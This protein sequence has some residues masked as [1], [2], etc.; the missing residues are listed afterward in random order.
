MHVIGTAGHVDHGKSSL[1][2]R[3]TGINPDRL[4]VEQDREM[5]IELG[6]AWLQLPNGEDIGIVDVPGHRDFIENML[7]GVGGIDAAL[8]VVAADEGV[9]PQ[10]REHL[11]IL[12]L[13]Q[14]PAGLIALN[15]VDL[16]DD[17]EWL[18]LVETDLKDILAGTV[19][20]N[21][22]I[23]RVSARTGAGLENLLQH[24]QDILS[25]HPH[26]PDLGRPRLPVDRVFTL[27]GFGTIVTG[28][29]LDGH[30]S[31]GDTVEIL[32]AGITGRIRSLQTHKQSEEKAVPGSR[33]AVN[34]SG[35]HVDQIKRGDVITYP[36][37][38]E[39]TKMMDVWCTLLDDIDSPLKHN[40]EVKLFLG[41]AEVMAR[42]R[43]LGVQELEPGKDTFL[44][45]MLQ[46]P[47]VAQRQDR[48]IIRRP[49]PSA[50]IGGGQ[51]VDPHPLR[52]HKRF[53]PD[54]LAELEQL[55]VGTPEEILMQSAHSLVA[56]Q[57][58]EIIAVSGLEPDIAN[59][60]LKVLLENG[61]LLAL[62]GSRIIIP[63]DM[64]QQMKNTMEEILSAYHDQYPL[65]LGMPREQL[66]SQLAFPSG[67]FDAVVRQMSTEQTLVTYQAKVRLAGH[68]VQFTKEQQKA[69]NQLL[70][71]FQEQPTTPPSVKQCV[72]TIGEELTDALL[73]TGQLVQPAEDVVFLP[74]IFEEMQNLAIEHLRTNGSITLAELRDQLHTSRKYAVAVLEF[75][76]S[77]G[78]TV[79][80]GDSRQ[81]RR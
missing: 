11:A 33:T 25:Q 58:G 65:R 41:A 48:F 28:T 17:P 13:L 35:V 52:R 49:S 23:V 46:E 12:D 67:L 20:A 79:R 62:N 3:L 43:V 75:L 19:L 59:T 36:G 7:A 1:I 76:D 44:Q 61:S 4:K 45:L 72:E 37:T 34:I 8:F 21:A 38:F 63:A 51:V 54:R 40:S 16:V 80:K 81:L 50:T 55:L 64:L 29:L 57:A 14:I 32:P 68:Q 74:A 10:T 60:A 47:V 30:L 39:P 27:P 24:L 18:D 22:P 42:V 73:E 66:K 78:V 6:F 26:R 71:Q 15:K 53:N 69:I 2:K 9:M 56:G 77:S 5:S 31:V 70:L